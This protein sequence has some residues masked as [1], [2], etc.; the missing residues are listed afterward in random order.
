M[1][2]ELQ[3]PYTFMVCTGTSFFVTLTRCQNP[4]SLN[5]SERC[6]EINALA[7]VTELL[8]LDPLGRVLHGDAKYRFAARHG[9]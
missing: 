5:L 6:F 2:L 4:E 9:T 7:A 3:S 1:E 8:F